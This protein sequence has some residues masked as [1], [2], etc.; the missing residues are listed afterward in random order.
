[1]YY[2]GNNSVEEEE[3]DKGDP[4]WWCHRG[5]IDKNS[6]RKG[7]HK[8]RNKNITVL[9]IWGGRKIILLEQVG[10]L[11]VCLCVQFA[12]RPALGDRLPVPFEGLD[13]HHQGGEQHQ[14]GDDFGGVVE[15]EL[16][17]I[18]ILDRL[19]QLLERVLLLHLGVEY[20]AQVAHTLGGD[21]RVRGL[22]LLL[23]LPLAGGRQLRQ[24]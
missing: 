17:A 13:H 15:V 19:R 20:L 24:Q 23:L 14:H 11:F 4:G 7:R 1:M 18:T 6:Y 22:L 12:A 9:D 16:E 3:E 2:G 10:C 21:G 5:F 8:D